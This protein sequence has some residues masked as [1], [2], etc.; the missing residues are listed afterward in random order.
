[1]CRKNIGLN[2]M[3]NLWK[4]LSTPKPVLGMQKCSWLH[5][6]AKT[7]K[8]GK[9]HTEESQMKNECVW[10]ERLMGINRGAHLLVRVHQ[11][12]DFYYCIPCKIN[13][14]L[15]QGMLRE[16]CYRAV[17]KLTV[18]TSTSMNCIK[19]CS[20][21]L[22]PRL[23]KLSLGW[24]AGQLSFTV[25]IPCCGWWNDDAVSVQKLEGQSGRR[26]CSVT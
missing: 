5:K 9:A 24:S 12:S 14:K 16:K 18:S 7:N 19:Q 6:L 23:N 13:F 8:W 2:V 26:M 1:M 17:R 3:K 15:F 11:H 4:V 21:V 22:Q 10:I 25:S 20:F